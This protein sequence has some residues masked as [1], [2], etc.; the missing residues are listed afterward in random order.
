MSPELDHSRRAQGWTPLTIRCGSA[1]RVAGSCK[2]RRAGGTC[3]YYGSG[4]DLPANNWT[5]DQGNALGVPVVD[6]ARVR[7]DRVCCG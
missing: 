6:G 3:C 4:A 2:T 7:P 5:V 1:A